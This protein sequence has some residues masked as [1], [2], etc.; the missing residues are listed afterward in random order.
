MVGDS[1][2]KPIEAYCPLGGQLERD[3]L[4]FRI[5]KD[6]YAD[7]PYVMVLQVKDEIGTLSYSSLL[8]VKYSLS[9]YDEQLP[10]EVLEALV[11]ASNKR[12]ELGW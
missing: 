1:Q 6:P 9:F 7:L 10:S 3:D 4:L 12:E 8:Y 2:P 5:I 11:D